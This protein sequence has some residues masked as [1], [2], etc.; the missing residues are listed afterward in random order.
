VI[1]TAVYTDSIYAEEPLPLD[2]WVEPCASGNVL[3]VARVLMVNE[4]T[5]RLAGHTGTLEPLLARQH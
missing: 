3:H 1:S 4:C 5:E 2:L